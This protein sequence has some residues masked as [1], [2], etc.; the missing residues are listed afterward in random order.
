MSKHYL[1]T[2][3]WSVGGQPEFGK[4]RMA[5][6]HRIDRTATAIDVI[7]RMVSNSAGEPDASGGAPL[8]PWAVQGLMA[9]VESLC[10]YIRLT[11]EGMQQDAQRFQQYEG[12]SQ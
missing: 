10:H 12:G 5:A 11:T 8:D 1:T 2:D 6:I 7:A 9:G 3:N 4:V